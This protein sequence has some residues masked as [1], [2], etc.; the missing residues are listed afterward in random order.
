[1]KKCNTRSLKLA[2]SNIRNPVLDLRPEIYARDP[3]LVY[4]DGILYM[5]YT[6]VEQSPEKIDLYLEM[7]K[8]EDMREWDQPVRLLSSPLNFSSPGNVIRRDDK[9][10][11]CFQSYPIE[12]GKVWGSEASRLWT[13]CSTDLEDWSDPIMMTDGCSAEWAD[14]RRQIDP[15]IIEGN[16]HYHCFY[17]SHGCLGC[18]ISSDLSNWEEGAFEKPAFSLLINDCKTAVENPCILKDGD[19]FVLFFSLCGKGRGIAIARS[20][21][22]RDWKDIQYLDLPAPAWATG[23]VTA[24]MVID[25]RDELG[26]W[27]MAFH[28]DIENKEHEAA[29]GFAYSD[30]LI[31]WQVPA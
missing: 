21:D 22:L 14:S 3:A 24:A 5:F 15:Y 23:G 10:F 26:V 30:D 1:M 18:L 28:G 31:N 17:K 13:M 11:L 2:V 12:P 19:E 29:I 8:T 9:W 7:T 16:K 4:N 27:L 6:A 25:L 20:R